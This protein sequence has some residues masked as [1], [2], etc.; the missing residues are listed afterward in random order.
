[1][2]AGVAETLPT[3]YLGGDAAPGSNPH[4]HAVQARRR[5]SADRRSVRAF[6]LGCFVKSI[7]IE[8]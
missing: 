5:T 7:G 4:R 2:A 8:D 6:G 1:M 3:G